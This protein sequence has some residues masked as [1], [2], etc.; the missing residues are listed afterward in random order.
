MATISFECKKSKANSEGNSPIYFRITVGDKRSYRS[1]GIWVPE[2]HWNARKGEVRKSIGEDRQ[3]EINTRLQQIRTTAQNKINELNRKGNIITTREIK[4]VVDSNPTSQP[5]AAKNLLSYARGINDPLEKSSYN[6]YKKRNTIIN[7]LDTYT[8]G[9]G[10]DFSKIDRSWVHS[11]YTYLREDQGN[12]KNT[13]AKAVSILSSFFEAAIKDEV[14]S[15]RN[16]FRNVTFPKE[17]IYKEKLTLE[18]VQRLKDLELNRDTWAYHSRNYWL[19][20]MYMAGMRISDLCKL[21]KSDISSGRVQYRMKKTKVLKSIAVSPPLQEILDLYKENESTNMFP[22]LRKSVGDYVND[23]ELSQEIGRLNALI[24]KNLKIVQKKAGIKKT[25]STHI[26][27]HTF[28]DLARKDG[29]SI[30]DISKALA[31]KSI[32]VTQNYLQKLDTESLDKKM[33]SL[34]N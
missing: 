7:H 31:H 20:Q 14:T 34:F 8:E 10:V 2:K 5:A 21:Q 4:E 12:S 27:R 28:A 9:R 25:L 11:F 24:N 1:T 33:E 17:D 32:L 23:K 30:Y 29:W 13:A 19:A 22:I 3:T 16:P 6:Y 15:Y 18:E 26:A